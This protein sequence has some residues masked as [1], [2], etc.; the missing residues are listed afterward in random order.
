M[1]PKK[2]LSR[3]IASFRRPGRNSLSCTTPFF[4]PAAFAFRASASAISSRSEIGFSQ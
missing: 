1:R 3:S 2:P 4:T